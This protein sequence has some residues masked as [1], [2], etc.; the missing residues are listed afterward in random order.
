MKSY[1]ANSI[2]VMVLAIG[3]CL[4]VQPRA[5]YA[6]QN[7]ALTPEKIKAAL[8]EAYTKFKDVKEV[9]GLL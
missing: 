2:R 8:S 1:L 3:I 4:F 7:N 6:Q 5:I 9:A